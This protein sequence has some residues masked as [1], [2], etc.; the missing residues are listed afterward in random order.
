MIFLR[1]KLYEFYYHS[2]CLHLSVR[3][4]VQTDPAGH[5]TH[6]DYIYTAEYPADVTYVF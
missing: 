1:P 5:A 6:R 4:T 3:P 2:I